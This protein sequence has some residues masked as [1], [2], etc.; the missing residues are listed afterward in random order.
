MEVY[1]DDFIQLAQ[2]KNPEQ[3]EHLSCAILHGIH[4][5]LPPPNVTGHDGKDPVSIKKLKQG[6]GMWA[7]GTFGVGV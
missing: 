6:N 5:V 7:K 3:L 2:T 1:V 4:S